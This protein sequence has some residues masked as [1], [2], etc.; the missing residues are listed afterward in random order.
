MSIS[1]KFLTANLSISTKLFRRLHNY[2]FN[3]FYTYCHE[4]DYAIRMTELRTDAK[5]LLEQLKKNND[6]YPYKEFLD[7]DNIFV[8]MAVHSAKRTK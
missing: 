4:H 5:L 7:K 3:V 8:Q 2:E 1:T 6:E